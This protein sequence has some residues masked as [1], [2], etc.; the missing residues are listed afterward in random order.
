MDMERLNSAIHALQITPPSDGEQQHDDHHYAAEIY[1][2]QLLDR[3][4]E[5]EE[6]TQNSIAVYDGS[7]YVRDDDVVEINAGGKIIAARRNTL[8]QLTGA[9]G[10]RHYLVVGGI[11]SCK[12]TAAAEY[13]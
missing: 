12:K 1:K 3:L 10:W 13:F 4:H 7:E 2:Q 5:F 9:R 8:C 11:K 6:R